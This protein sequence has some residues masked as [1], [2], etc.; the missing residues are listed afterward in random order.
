MATKV[1]YDFYDYKEEALYSHTNYFESI[2]EAREFIEHIE[3][4]S[5]YDNIELLNDEYYE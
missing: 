3:T 2:E 1:T 4:L 5:G